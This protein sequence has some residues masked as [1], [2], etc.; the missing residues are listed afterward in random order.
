MSENKT[1][2]AIL[3]IISIFLLGA[4]AFGLT[5]IDGINNKNYNTNSSSQTANNNE[6]NT[7]KIGGDQKVTESIS[8]SLQSIAASKITEEPKKEVS[9]T[10]E[11]TKPEIKLANIIDTINSNPEINIFLSAVKAAGLED[12]L[13]G[14]GPFTV[15]A[16]NNEAFTKYLPAETLA[17]LQ[18]PENKDKL[19]GILKGHVI[20]T[21][22]L[23]S[24]LHDGQYLATQ[25]GG[26]LLVKV[27]GNQYY[28]D[29]IFVTKPNI[30]ATNG[31]IHII[32]RIIPE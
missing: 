20:A 21:K 4:V 22:L 9:A 19:A 3:A 11:V 12:T 15:F 25:Q 13:K 24:D 6:L 14:D 17:D 10:K 5:Q 1:L 29:D 30:E 16:P 26:Q 7:S 8:T 2:T 27:A 32:N 31:V 28:I 18:K 23:S